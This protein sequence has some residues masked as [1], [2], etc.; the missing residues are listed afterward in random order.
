[1]LMLVIAVAVCRDD[2]G[3]RGSFLLLQSICWKESVAE[4]IDNNKTRQKTK[5]RRSCRIRGINIH[6]ADNIV[7][8]VAYSTLLDSVLFASFFN[9]ILDLCS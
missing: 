3:D 7:L 9:S 4:H 2:L 1:M 8:L 5:D 6:I